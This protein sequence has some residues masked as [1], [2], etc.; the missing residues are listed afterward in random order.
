M[1]LYSKPISRQVIE[2]RRRAFANALETLE[3]RRLLSATP[4]AYD[5]ATYHLVPRTPGV[6]VNNTSQATTAS[7]S[8]H[9]TIIPTFDS[10][11]TND[12]NAATIEASL[13]SAI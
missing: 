12:P 8:T 10:S 13:N 5:E 11:I 1:M 2:R 6:A 4:V 3:N 7:A 9:L